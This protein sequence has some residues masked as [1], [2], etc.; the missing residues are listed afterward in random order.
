MAKQTTSADELAIFT[1]SKIY[2]RHTVIFNASKPWTTLE[3]D[4]EM[5][6]EQLFENC[7][8]HLAYMGKDQYATLH[9]KPFIKPA[10]P[11]TL[12][13]MLEP[14]KLKHTSKHLC[15]QEP[16]DLSL[17][18]PQSAD[19]SLEVEVEFGVI[20]A[21]TS[22]KSEETG[23][24]NSDLLGDNEIFSKEINTPVVSENDTMETSE[25]D[26]YKKALDAI[27]KTWSEVK[28]LQM[29]ASDIE[30]YMNKNKSPKGDNTVPDP[31]G[32]PIP[33][34]RSGRPIRKPTTAVLTEID[35]TDGDSD[36]ESYFVKSPRKRKNSKPNASGPL[37]S[38]VAAQNK[39]SG[40]P[41]MVF[42]STSNYQRSDSPEFSDNEMDGDN[43]SSSGSSQSFEPEISD[44]ESDKTFDGFDESDV[45]P[46]PKTG[47]GSL[48]TVQF[49][50]KRRKRLRIYRCHEKNC[51]YS[52]KSLRELNQ[53]HT[54]NHGEVKCTGCDKH[55]KTPSLMKHHAY[56][57][58][59]L[60]FVCDMCKE[61]F[62]FNSELKFHK[63][64]HRKV[65]SY[66]CVAKNCGKS[67][68]SSNELNKHAQKHLGV[69]WECSEC[70]YTTDDRRNLR[71]HHK[72]HQKIGSHKCIPCNKSLTFTCN[73]KGIK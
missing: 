66:H 60:P 72:K 57:N 51:A 1:L 49:G 59:K 73:L 25:C 52:G 71:G 56:C 9:R 38:R 11:P 15:Q 37:A 34:S 62:A 61:G 6:E 50:L 39:R 2:Q 23:E 46:L 54:D 33:C 35:A 10:A 8:I 53:H 64:V 17:P 47:K 55:F 18:M 24:P 21:D 67:Y 70:D 32:S 45:K 27:C 26:K 28:L 63:M 36:Y 69:S 22:Q 68:K 48:N 31:P 41:T 14:M 58:G 40:I 42:P 7:Q 65:H 16:M 30:F 4:G 29:K 19:S 43:A 5:L 44:G 20:N 3:P 12:K 13:S